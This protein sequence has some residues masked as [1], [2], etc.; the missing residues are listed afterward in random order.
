VRFAAPRP[1]L[2]EPAGEAAAA[3]VQE[4]ATASAADGADETLATKT[5]PGTEVMAVG[6]NTNVEAA[7]PAVKL[8]EAVTETQAAGRAE[9]RAANQAIADENSAAVDHSRTDPGQ[10]STGSGPT[11][12]GIN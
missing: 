6:E 3:A 7:A 8:A 11:S 10:L 2:E 4:A 1:I 12:S 9:K 5:G